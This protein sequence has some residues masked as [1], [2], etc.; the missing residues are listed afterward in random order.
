MATKS[1]IFR[2]DSENKGSGEGESSAIYRVLEGYWVWIEGVTRSLL[3][4]IG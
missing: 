4:F 1:C 3:G 2:Y